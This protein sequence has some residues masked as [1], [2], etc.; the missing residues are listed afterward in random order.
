[1]RPSGAWAPGSH[2]SHEAEMTKAGPHSLSAGALHSVSFRVPTEVW[3]QV[4]PPWGTLSSKLHLP[5][6]LSCLAS[7]ILFCDGK[8]TQGIKEDLAVGGSFSFPTTTLSRNILSAFRVLSPRMD[9]AYL[10]CHH[11]TMPLCWRGLFM[12]VTNVP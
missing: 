9:H 8:K 12:Y 11:W 2:C 6:L 1:M 7:V 5:T 3:G 10:V 4:S